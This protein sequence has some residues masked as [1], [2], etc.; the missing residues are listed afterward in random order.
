MLWAHSVSGYR[1]AS[2]FNPQ[3][4]VYRLCKGSCD[5]LPRAYHTSIPDEIHADADVRYDEAYGQ[6]HKCAEQHV[7]DE[8][9]GGARK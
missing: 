5:L 6:A 3:T 4:V 9:V 8:K 2:L 1:S 7:I